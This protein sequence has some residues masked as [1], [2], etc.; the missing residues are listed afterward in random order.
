MDIGPHFGVCINTL[1]SFYDIIL[2]EL[3]IGCMPY[4]IHIRYGPYRMWM[5]FDVIKTRSIHLFLDYQKEVIIVVAYK[6]YA[7]TRDF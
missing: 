2:C 5:N 1:I 6:S 4:D 3:K 7:S